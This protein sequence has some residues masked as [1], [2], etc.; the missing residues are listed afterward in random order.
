M[1]GKAAIMYAAQEGDATMLLM[2]L[3]PGQKILFSMKAQR[4]K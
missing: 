1:A 3:K 4:D 2:A